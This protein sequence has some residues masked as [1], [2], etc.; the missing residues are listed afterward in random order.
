MDADAVLPIAGVI[1]EPHRFGSASSQ[2][3]RGVANKLQELPGLGRSWRRS[4]YLGLVRVGYRKIVRSLCMF[5]Q[6]PS[7]RA[8]ERL[9][10]LAARLRA[11]DY[12][13][14][15]QRLCSP[16]IDAVFDPDKRAEGSIFFSV[17]RQELEQAATMLERFCAA[18]NVAFNVEASVGQIDDRHLGLLMT[19]RS[20]ERRVGKACKSV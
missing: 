19:I 16:D 18:R 3:L 13:V 5:T 6:R 15:A 7:E 12:V 14:Q 11:A 17:G 2:Q 9:R 1:F 8:I 10:A 20:E 4:G